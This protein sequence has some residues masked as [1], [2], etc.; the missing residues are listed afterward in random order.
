[1]EGL[2]GILILLVL[3][4]LYIIGLFAISQQGMIFHF[5]RK[6]F[7]TSSPDDLEETYRLP[8]VF[9]PLIGCPTCMASVHSTYF[10]WG[11]MPWN[12]HSLIIYPLYAIALAGLNA[13][14]HKYFDSI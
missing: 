5:L 4:S 12:E 8:Y 2:S 9:K 3:N 10:F 11:V 7:I 13:L 1:M 14:I 6:A